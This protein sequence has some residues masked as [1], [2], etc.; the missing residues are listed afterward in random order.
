MLGRFWIA[1]VAAFLWMMPYLWTYLQPRGRYLYFW[2]RSDLGG[3]LLAALIIATVLYL[4][5]L[6]AKQWDRTRLLRLLQGGFVL[7]VVY[8]LC[9]NLMR[10]AEQFSDSQLLPTLAVLLLLVGLGL[11][12]LRVRFK[13]EGLKDLAVIACWA[14]SVVPFGFLAFAASGPDQIGPP[15]TFPTNQGGA[16]R[17]NVYLF[18]LDDWSYR[19]CFRDGELIEELP[20]LAALSRQ[21][22]VFHRAYLPSRRAS[23]SMK[24]FLGQGSPPP[25]HMPARMRERGFFTAVVG[26][27]HNYRQILGEQLDYCR[28]FCGYKAPGQGPL[29]AALYHLVKTARNPFKR[30]P[31]DADKLLDSYVMN[32]MHARRVPVFHNLALQ[33]IRCTAA[34]TFAV[35]QYPLPHMPYVFDAHGTKPQ[36]AIYQRTLENYL[37]NLRHVDGLVGEIILALK[38]S[39]KFEEA[40]VI[41]TSNH[42]WLDDSGLNNQINEHY[43]Q[44]NHV[45]LIFKAPGQAH[46]VDTE[47][48]FATTRLEELI[49]MSLAGEFDASAIDELVATRQLSA[50]PDPG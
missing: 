24:A 15:E 4:P 30:L 2:Q 6:I 31:G 36:L 40:V 9:T 1:F 12:G 35:I 18:V 43:R 34:P 41:F 26:Y 29:D 48:T 7:V 23:W 11:V 42:D 47:A 20:N 37:D 5:Y 49:T 46:R 25:G 44:V 50:P 38:S 27:Y 32:R 33:L 3:I 22:L 17:K 16:A 8:L 39:G 21:S 14:L 45:P 10:L 13:L 28:S 19:R